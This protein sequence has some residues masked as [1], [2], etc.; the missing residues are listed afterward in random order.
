MTLGFE[1]HFGADVAWQG[2]GTYT[3]GERDWLT[4]QPEWGEDQNFSLT[5]DL[6]GEFEELVFDDPA[7]VGNPENYLYAEMDIEFEDGFL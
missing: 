6:S 4:F 2:Q 7:A 5:Y 1:Q 3:R